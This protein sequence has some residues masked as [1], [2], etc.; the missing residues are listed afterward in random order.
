VAMMIT[1]SLEEI[2]RIYASLPSAAW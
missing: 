1:I 2:K